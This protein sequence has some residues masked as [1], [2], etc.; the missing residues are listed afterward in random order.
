LNSVIELPFVANDFFNETGEYDLYFT[1]V[2]DGV[3]L[4]R[5]MRVFWNGQWD[6]I[7]A[8]LMQPE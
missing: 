2:A 5:M 6:G 7:D 8:Q 4:E 1:V 3:P